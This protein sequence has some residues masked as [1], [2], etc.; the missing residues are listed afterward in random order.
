LIAVRL[1]VRARASAGSI[2]W[3]W[4]FLAGVATGSSIW[5]THFI[6]MLA[7]QPSLPSAFEATLTVL[8]LFIAIGATTSGLAVASWRAI[9]LSGEIGGALVG[10]GIAAMHYTGM[11]AYRVA[12]VIEWDSHLVVASIVLGTLLG[13]VAFN[14]AVR[15][16]SRSWRYGAAGIL[17]LAICTLHF[18]AMGAVLI[19][20]DP[21][22]LIPPRSMSSDMLGLS[23]AGVGLLVIGTG[24]SSYLIDARSRSDA[25][26]RLHHLAFHDALSGLPNRAAFNERLDLEIAQAKLNDGALAILS[27]DLNRFKEINDVFGHA[28]GDRVLVEVSRRMAECLRGGEFLARLGGDEFVVIQASA[29]QPGDASDLAERLSAAVTDRLALDGHSMQLGASIG[30]AIYPTDGNNRE[31]IL[32]NADVAMY[33]AKT[34]GQSATCFFESGMDDTVRRRRAL[35]RELEAAVGQGQLEIFYQVQ[36][37]VRDPQISGFEALLRWHHPTRGLVPPAEFI[38]LA[39]ETGLIL[40]IGEWALRTACAAAASWD[41]PYRIAVNLSPVQFSHGDLPDLVHRILLETGLAASRL[42]LEITESTLMSN[43]DRTLHSL[44]RLKA[45]G[46]TIAMDDFGTG[47]SSLATLQ[48][49]PFD[50]IKLDRSF[51]LKLE[52]RP[53]SVAIIRAML[54]LGRSLN[55]PVM[56][57]GVE[58]EKHLEFLCRE[59]CEEIQGFLLGRPEPMSKI[60]HLVFERA[61]KGTPEPPQRLRA[62][63]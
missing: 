24:F 49:F 11:A 52:S 7:F 10:L 37:A 4:L 43:P 29:D 8:S 21:T 15:R 51:L 61:D 48:T 53:Q 62:A 56:A 60:R 57:E 22:I 26:D 13:A 28:T 2:R 16:A 1:F 19:V 18:T 27:L 55:I 20:P 23:I 40:S 6:A 30:V 46:V 47:Y 31:R 14:L 5:S 63:G 3:G 59:G 58:S 50:K 35:S 45:L 54:S 9:P 36:I 44:R 34:M 38:P 41:K 32:A 12:G 39:E 25:Q 17:T 33:R 42:E